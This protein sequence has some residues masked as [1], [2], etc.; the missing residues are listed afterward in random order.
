MPPRSVGEADDGA[1]P[2]PEVFE[3]VV[4]A[5]FGRKDVDDDVAEVEEHPTAVGRALFVAEVVAFGLQLFFQVLAEGAKLEW[6]LGRGDH[7]VI[8]ERSGARN[9]E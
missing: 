1:R 9:I 3:A 8:R 4:L 6:R 7:E 2:R 5:L